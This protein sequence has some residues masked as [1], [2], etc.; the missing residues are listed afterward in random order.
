MIDIVA[1]NAYWIMEEF[2]IILKFYLRL[3]NLFIK[4][5]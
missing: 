2:D 5:K 4:Y 1:K 3:T